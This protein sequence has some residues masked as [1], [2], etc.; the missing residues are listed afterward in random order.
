MSLC[1]QGGLGAGSGRGSGHA[2]GRLAALAY[3]SRALGLL[4]GAV[5][6][7]FAAMQG[8]WQASSGRLQ[9]CRGL[10]SVAAVP[11][12]CLNNGDWYF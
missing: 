10:S 8:R 12:R 6:L 11:S 2:A 7:G 5:C 4:L 1:L 9:Q 3:A